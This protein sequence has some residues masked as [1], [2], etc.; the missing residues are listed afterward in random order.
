MESQLAEYLGKFRNRLSASNRRYIEQMVVVV[1]ALLTY[2]HKS[3]GAS[4][5]RTHEMMTGGDDVWPLRSPSRSDQI[6]SDQPEH[7]SEK[8]VEKIGGERNK[9]MLLTSVDCFLRSSL[10]P[11]PASEAPCCWAQGRVQ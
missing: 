4:T 1:K 9:A 6:R 11:T 5:R 3:T 7:K 8:L 10:L 2:I